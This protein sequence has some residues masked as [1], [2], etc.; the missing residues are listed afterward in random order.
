VTAL[1]FEAP[2]LPGRL[3][4]RISVAART[5]LDDV[6]REHRA[7]LTAR[8]LE[9]GA[10]LFRGFDVRTVGAFDAFAGAVSD[11]RGDYIYRST[12]RTRVGSGIFT[13]S[14]YPP[15]EE[16]PLHNEN[17]YQRSWPTSIAFCCVTPAV[18]G[19]ATP[20]ADMRE[21]TR[22]LGAE[23]VDRFEARRVRYI[24][25]YQP[26]VDLPWQTVFQTPDPVEATRY[27]TINDIEC[28]WLEPGVLR[29]T[30]VCQGVARHAVTGERLW[31]NQAHLF[32]LSS[33]GR[34]EQQLLLDTVGAERLPRNACHGD[35][36]HI[37]ADDLDAVR[38][39]F[40]AHAVTF[41]WQAGDVLMLDNMQVAHGRERYR[42]RREVLT[43][44]LDPWSPS[45]PAD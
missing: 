27:C 9:H 7:L 35:G 29:T 14:E 31:F 45:G 17:S 33:L 38:A 21:V 26:Y 13:A 11:R 41:P 2:P 37:A 43:V 5:P 6:F 25:H 18:S 24:R 10:L 16:I 34:E 1:V 39:A 15:D 40:R 30:Q 22:D 8:L 4:L 28:Q 32:H 44:M 19:G 3:L 12:P 42:G 20:I 36:G 23:R